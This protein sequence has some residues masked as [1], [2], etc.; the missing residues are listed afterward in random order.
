MMPRFWILTA[1]KFLVRSRRTTLALG[2][3]IASAVGMLVFITSIAI[4]INDSMIQNSTGLFSGQIT[5]M[6]LPRSVQP[7]S[8]KKPGV[9][10]VLQRFTA[11]G[12]LADKGRTTPLILV[13]VD[14]DAE[15]GTTRLWEKIIQGH[16]FEAGTHQILISQ[17][18]A[19]LMGLIP[20]SQVHFTSS[21][22]S[23]SLT[24][25]GIYRT[26]IDRYD[27]GIGFC[28]GTLLAPQATTWDCALFLEPGQDPETV[29]GQFDDQGFRQAYLKTWEEQMPD[30]KQLIELNRISMGF[31]MILVLGVVS[32][33][34]ACAFA[35]VIVSMI[36]EY[37]IMKAMGVTPAETTFLIVSQVILMNLMATAAGTLAGFAAVLIT[38]ETG[39]DLSGFTSHNQYFVV[40]GLI[41][42]RLTWGALALPSALALCFSLAAAA[43]PAIIVARQRTS[44]IL[45]TI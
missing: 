14:P 30:L 3:M 10:Q 12:S 8:L 45:R 15:S 26:G 9:R 24:V 27:R 37:G 22:L 4:G 21:G 32:F 39:I 33:G 7:G 36:R 41:I 18:T 42:P 28:P 43:W 35:I 16:F 29:A 5:G 11:S 6:G 19:D 25:A 20:G 2:C 1:L 40:S 31:V 34:I 13:G 23:I 38:A 44:E 17:P